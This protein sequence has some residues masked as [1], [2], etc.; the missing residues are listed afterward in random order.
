MKL[1]SEYINK[2]QRFKNSENWFLRQ[3]YVINISGLN[4]L[5]F[6]FK[7]SFR[8]QVI[9]R[10]LYRKHFHQVSHY[11]ETDRYPDLFSICRDY[12]RDRPAPK[13]LSFGCSTGEEV[14]SLGEYMPEATIVGTDI[15]RW[16]IKQCKEK[17]PDKR[18]L[19]IHVLSKEF[20]SQKHFDAIFCLAVFQ[21]PEN[22]SN[23]NNEYSSKYSFNQFEEQLMMLDTKLKNGGLLIIDQCDFNFFE[24]GLASKYFPLPVDNNMIERDRPLF[25]KQNQKISRSSKLF[26]VFIKTRT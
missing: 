15:S 22:R 25:S 12:F 4:S 23:P 9:S 18:Y 16:C 19:F 6:I 5:R 8:E 14:F 21:H 11:T 1:L 24:T 7:S 3:F 13:I 17:D 20:Q 10:I 2:I 26:R